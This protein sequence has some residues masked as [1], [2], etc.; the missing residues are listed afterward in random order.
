MS[1]NISMRSKQFRMGLMNWKGSNV[2]KYSV[3]QMARPIQN[4]P[5]L[6]NYGR[7]SGKANPIRHHR[8]RGA[9][10]YGTDLTCD[11]DSTTNSVKAILIGDEVSN[12]TACCKGTK[13][14][15]KGYSY[16]IHSASSKLSTDYTSSTSEYLKSRCKSYDSRQI[17]SKNDDNKSTFR[18]SNY[19][20]Y[21]STS[22]PTNRCVT[23]T[24]KLSN[25]QYSTNSAVSS[26]SRLERLK[27]NA[28]KK[29]EK[30]NNDTYGRKHPSWKVNKGESSC[31]I[32]ILRA[33]RPDKYTVQCK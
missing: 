7:V 25:P 18:N 6:Q 26:S 11:T 23:T 28:N 12:E 32:S 10:S 30:S 13:P 5:N 21:I 33:G 2:T 20:G 8:L 31:N 4:T 15:K 3:P 24:Y 1:T 27:Y 16:Q 17:V 9:Q 19:Q 22:C 29:W 14:F